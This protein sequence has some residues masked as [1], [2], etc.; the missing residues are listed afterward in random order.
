MPPLL[1]HTA[2]YAAFWR[3]LRATRHGKNTK[4]L[5]LRVCRHIEQA[6]LKLTDQKKSVA[7][8]RINHFLIWNNLVPSTYEKTHQYYKNRFS[9][10]IFCLRIMY[11]CFQCELLV[12]LWQAGH[13]WLG[14]IYLLG[15]DMWVGLGFFLFVNAFLV[16]CNFQTHILASVLLLWSYVISKQTCVMHQAVSLCVLGHVFTIKAQFLCFFITV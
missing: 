11:L 5:W 9:C 8:K 4:L 7:D 16:F 15:L 6:W 12:D 14:R 1:I 13:V 3:R 10:K 2:R